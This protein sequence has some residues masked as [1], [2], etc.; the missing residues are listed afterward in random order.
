MKKY[1]FLCGAMVPGVEG[2]DFHVGEVVDENRIP[3]SHLR[4]WLQSGIIAE[5]VE[6]PVTPETPAPVQ[7]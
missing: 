3:P 6:H 2:A 1:R 7:G 5:D 4:G